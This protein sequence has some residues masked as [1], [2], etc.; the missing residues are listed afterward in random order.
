MTNKKWCLVIANR[1]R[2]L[3]NFGRLHFTT[4][5]LANKPL[6]KLANK[7]LNKLANKPL[8]KSNKPLNK[9]NKQ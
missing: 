3:N 9:S 2:K 7:P 8:N 6:N 1:L 5:K 4:T